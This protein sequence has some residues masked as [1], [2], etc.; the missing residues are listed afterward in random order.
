MT[1]QSSKSADFYVGFNGQNR[2]GFR[3]VSVSVECSVKRDVGI[4]DDS[5]HG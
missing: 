1:D 4:T 5:Y 2:G 3:Y